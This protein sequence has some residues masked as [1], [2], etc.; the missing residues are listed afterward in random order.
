MTEN[1]NGQVVTFYSYKGGT[2]RTMALANV[3]W[4]LAA[5]GKRVLVVDWDLESPGLHRFF[6]PFI[7]ASLLSTTGGVIDLINEFEWATT[8]E[9]H[10]DEQWHLQ[11]A[12]VHRHAFSLN[13]PHF[14]EGGALD[15]LSAGKQNR[16]YVAT[17]NGLDWDTFYTKLGGG[18]FFDALRVDMQRNY[19]YTL[20]DSR[21]GLSDVADIC[22]IHLPDVLVDCFTFSEQGIDGAAQVAHTV[23]HRYEARNIRILPVPMRVDSAEKRKADAGRLVAMQR[24]A[25]LP[26]DLTDDE[27]AGYWAAMQVPYQAFYSYE[28]TLATFADPPGS[29]TTLLSAYETL[30]RYLTDGEVTAL[31]SM[32]EALRDRVNARFVRHPTVAEEE[33]TLRYAP[34]DQTW[35]EWIE[36]VLVAAGVRVNDPWASGGPVDDSGAASARQLTIISHANAAWHTGIITRDHHGTRVP[37]AVYVADMLPLSGFPISSSAF[38]AGQ[39]AAVAVERI[40]KLVGHPGLDAESWSGG[41]GPRF[42]GDE[43]VVFNAP[44]RNARFTGRE[45]DLRRLRAQLRTGRP[46]VVLP[47]SLPVALQGMGG[48]GKTQV[49][50]EYAHR[51]RSAYDVVWWINSD[52]VTFIDVALADLGGRLGIPAQPNVADNTRVVLNALSRGEPYSRW[53]VIFDN[54]EDLL[55]VD[56]FLPQGRGHVLITSRDP[57]W[58]DR[59]HPIAVDV[60]ERRESIQH[61]RQRVPTIG[62]DEANRVAEVLGDLPIAIAAAGAWLADTGAPIEEYLRQI[63]RHGPDLKRPGEGEAESSPSVEATWDLS[64][65][66]LRDRSPAAYRLLQLC[67][68]LAPEIA[69]EVVYSDEMAAALATLDPSVSERMVRGRLVQQINR[70]AL[71]KLDV[72]EESRSAGE[73]PRGGL[74]QI[75]RLLQH[76]VR[77]RMSEQELADAR[78]QVH[79]VLAASRPR[80]EVDDPDT[81]RR[82]RTLWPHL[83]V[84]NAVNC[85]DEAVRHLLI[86]RV[87]YLWLLGDLDPGRDLAERIVRTWTKLLDKTEPE[88]RA[89]LRR[90]LLHMRFHLA[91][92]LRDQANFEDSRRLDEEV[93]D[94]QREMLGAEHPHTLM[95]AGGLAG[96]L[97]G[98][99]R[100]PEALKQD[101]QTYAAWLEYFGEDHPRTLTALSNLAASH[102]LM[103]DFRAARE[104]DELVHRRRRVVLSQNH[105]NTLVSAANIGRDLREAGEYERSVSVLSG[106]LDTFVEVWGPESRGALNAQANLAVSL[107]SAGR[108]DEAAGL[109]E[110]AYERLLDSFGQTSPDTMACRL[111]RSVNLLAQRFEERAARELDEVRK[112]YER[113]LGASHPHTL[114]CVNNQAAVARALND[115]QLARKLA[116]VAWK[117]LSRVL[118]ADHPYTLAA[119]MNLAIC[120]AENLDS[121]AARAPI[122]DAVAR[123]ARVI[124]PDHPDTLRCEANRALILRDL[125]HTGPEA[126]E[127]R[128]LDALARRIGVDHPAIR[129]LRDKRYLHRVIDPHPF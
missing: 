102:R 27:R 34:E 115:T 61:L 22:T 87:R 121:A 77:R 46:A 39:P 29:R 4:I 114:V 101:E 8:K 74:V 7:D 49:A 54:A 36:H 47:R 25:G 42:P 44:A 98:L 50:M 9:S 6:T 129:A 37:L 105:P 15:F 92:I 108:A 80:G 95:T 71:L 122:E 90:Q 11:Y 43:T 28:E 33:V 32:D 57:R 116:T 66:R 78:H 5:N 52:Q 21:T 76:V 126:D 1:R 123:L 17:L 14:P 38:V 16:D 65:Q 68:V 63:E 31:P 96:D 73:R 89:A 82:F 120:T 70:L 75:H 91:N 30:T 40:V 23:R 26:A 106:V 72:Q 109:L 119:Q 85:P 24:F 127:T 3:A 67:S 79:L 118:G 124:G 41:R 125:G 45:D 64:L 55:R 59:A 2:G 35:A 69:L 86:D 83:E 20:I 103:G 56:Q 111:S 62:R 51:F 104:R 12:K 58:G 107:R 60:F 128:V 10:R 48:I 19:D 97:R 13:W 113:S 117:N 88:D 53:L 84:S 112:A 93:L 100:Y 94:E 81:W 110:K 18:Q 99:G